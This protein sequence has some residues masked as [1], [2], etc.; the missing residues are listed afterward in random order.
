MPIKIKDIRGFESKETMNLALL[1]FKEYG[2][3]T[4]Y[5]KDELTAILYIIKATDERMFA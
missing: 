1:K 3:K 5:K 4:N 2:D